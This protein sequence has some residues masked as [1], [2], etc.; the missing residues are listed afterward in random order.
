M[1]LKELS[2]NRGRDTPEKGL[3]YCR[4]FIANLIINFMN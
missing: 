3:N 1:G 2:A 4:D